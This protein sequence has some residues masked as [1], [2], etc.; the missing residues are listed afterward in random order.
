MVETYQHGWDKQISTN[1]CPNDP[2]P[3]NCNT[4][5]C[6]FQG[7]SKEWKDCENCYLVQT[8]YNRSRIYL[9]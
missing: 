4:C 3:K 9:S 6:A 5:V 7:V 8:T 1:G 2:M